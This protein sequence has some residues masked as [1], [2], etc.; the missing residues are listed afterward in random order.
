METGCLQR[1]RRSVR[2]VPAARR[3][4]ALVLC[5]S[6]RSERLVPVDDQVRV[7]VER[8]AFLRTLPPAADPQFLLPR[9]KG[10]SSLL[11]SLRKTLRDDAG[12]VGIQA[13][14]VPHQLRHRCATS[15]LRAGVSLP[16]LMKLLGHHNANTTLLY[17]EVTQQDLQ[18]EYQAARL[19]P[20]HLVP[21]PPALRDAAPPSR[22]DATAVDAALTS[23]LRLLDLYR[24]LFAPSRADKQFLLLSR[25]LTRIRYLFEKSSQGLAEEK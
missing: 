18:R 23:T 5:Q 21:V 17:V 11:K 8:L 14:I 22:M 10:R 12:R 16:A 19:T 2:T 15:M 9:P 4:P 6:P 7:V 3:P 24:Q 13:H 20:R 1:G 25:R